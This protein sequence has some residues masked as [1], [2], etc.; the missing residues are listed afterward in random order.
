[1]Y[2]K[3]RPTLWGTQLFWSR[4][5]YVDL[6]RDIFFSRVKRAVHPL[7]WDRRGNSH[8]DYLAGAL[9]GIQHMATSINNINTNNPWFLIYLRHLNPLTEKIMVFF[10]VA[11]VET[12]GRWT[13]GGLKMSPVL[14]GIDRRTQVQNQSS[15]AIWK[16]LKW[17]IIRLMQASR[18][19]CLRIATP[20]QRQLWERGWRLAPIPALKGY[21][22]DPRRLAR[23]IPS[24]HQLE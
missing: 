15:Q 11:G 9:S 18:R 5:Y 21:A 23:P 8:L 3:S 20:E 19:I 7:E 2:R 16:D 10:P 6:R 14:V 4:P 12:N 13:G 22:V 1:M 24:S 17:R